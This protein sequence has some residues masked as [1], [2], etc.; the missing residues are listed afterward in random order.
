MSCLELETRFAGRIRERLYTPVEL[1]TG[2]VERHFADARGLGSLGDGLADGLGRL[3]VAR[4]LQ[5]LA[6]LLLQRG[7][8]GDHFRSGG[9]RH[10][11]IDMLRGAMDGQARNAE[12]ADMRP[13]LHCAPQAALFLRG[14]HFFLPSLRAIF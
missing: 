2:T 7:R 6:D 10:L 9:I 8:R 5:T 11:R 3:D 4:A 13:G 1:E 14:D 12:I